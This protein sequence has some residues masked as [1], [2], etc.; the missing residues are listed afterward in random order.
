MIK[1]L[2]SSERQTEGDRQRET[3]RASEREADRQTER[4][5]E[6]MRSIDDRR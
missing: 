5:T 6:I 3:V 1:I 2:I 4:E